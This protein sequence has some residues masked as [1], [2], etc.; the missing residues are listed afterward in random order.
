MA[1]AL[2]VTP[3]EPLDKCRGPWWRNVP[4]GQGARPLASPIFWSFLLDSQRVQLEAW[5]QGSLAD[6]WKSASLER[7][8]W[9]RL[10]KGQQTMSSMVF[11]VQFGLLRMVKRLLA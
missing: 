9:S 11:A 5:R 6:L 8:G 2:A 4:H 1:A 7:A 3:G 10:D